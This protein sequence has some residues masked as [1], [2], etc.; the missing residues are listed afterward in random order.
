MILI[1][2]EACF[3]VGVAG[4]VYWRM[5]EYSTFQYG[6]K[7][8]VGSKVSNGATVNDT[9]VRWEQFTC[10]NGHALTGI[11]NGF[12][13]H[14]PYPNDAVLIPSFTPPSGL[15]G[16][17]AV[18]DL[19][20]SCPGSNPSFSWSKGP[21][22]VSGVPI[23]YSAT[24]MDYCA[25]VKGSAAEVSSF[26]LEWSTGPYALYVEPSVLL[27]AP[28]ATVAR[29]HNATVILTVTSLHGF[30]GN[31]S[32]THIGFAYPSTGPWSGNLWV[33]P[34][35]LMVRAGGSNSTVVTGE[36]YQNLPAGTWN[37]RLYADAEYG[38]RFYGD[39]SGSATRTGNSTI[40]KITVT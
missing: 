30:D 33:N 1:I 18:Y 40:I 14:A 27:S 17:F 32:F 19:G 16:L 20:D 37:V 12:G 7:D 9:T 3:V 39:Y 23:A 38:L 31:L 8:L 21:P 28:N 29:G 2:A 13:D 34:K 4:P 10:P 36:A 11:H 6:C 22:L 15:L 24:V 5:N 35:S 25:V 26:S